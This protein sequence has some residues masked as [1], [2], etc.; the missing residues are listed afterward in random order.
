ME[1]KIY[2]QEEMKEEKCLIHGCR[3]QAKKV[4]GGLMKS[5]GLGPPYEVWRCEKGHKFLVARGKR[6]ATRKPRRDDG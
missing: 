5:V 3:A 1:D 6:P 4:T 2:S